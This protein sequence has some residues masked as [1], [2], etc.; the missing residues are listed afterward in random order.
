M[1]VHRRCRD[2]HRSTAIIGANGQQGGCYDGDFAATLASNPSS[3]SNGALLWNSPCEG[4]TA[5]LTVLNG[6]LYKGSHMHDCSYN[7]GGQYGGFSGSLS[8]STFVAY[9]LIAQDPT[10]GS[11]IH[12]SPN[13]NGAN[14][15]LV[16]PLA[17]T[18]DGTR[19]FLGGD[20]TTVNGSAREGLAVFSPKSITPS[21]APK[22]P[23]VAP[24]ATPGNG[25]VTVTFPA[26]TDTDNGVLTYTIYRGTST[27]VA[28]SPRSPG[29]GRSRRC[30]TPTPG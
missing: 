28:S 15:T 8:R 19:L 6:V 11:F 12:W 18:N 7:P 1:P 2:D 9:R 29:R 25:D 23:T 24:S 14:D 22:T 30:A 26:D 27:Q 20:F 16:G 3:S 5:S 21:A 13:T 17:M 4:A 10:N